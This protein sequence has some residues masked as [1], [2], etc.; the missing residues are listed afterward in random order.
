MVGAHGLGVL[1]KMSNEMAWALAYSAWVT[2]SAL[3]MVYESRQTV[4]IWKKHAKQLEAM[5]IRNALS[6][7]AY[8]SVEELENS[9]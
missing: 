8:H 2:I 7:H 3:G 1:A 9:N 5:L 4:K 6:G